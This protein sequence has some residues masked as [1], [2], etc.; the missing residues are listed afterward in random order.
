MALIQIFMEERCNEE[1][2]SILIESEAI[3]N[4]RDLGDG[5]KFAGF[6]SSLLF[7]VI[8]LITWSI[9]C[10]RRLS[11]STRLSDEL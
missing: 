6:H 10:S 8:A 1:V 7:S 3:M 4:R 9:F 5:S 2:L 11:C